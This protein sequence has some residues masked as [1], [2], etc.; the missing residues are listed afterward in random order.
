ML[1][2][3]AVKHSDRV[4]TE[5][6]NM[7]DQYEHESW[8]W[9]LPRNQRFSRNCEVPVVAD[10]LSMADRSLVA[11]DLILKCEFGL[12]IP[13]RIS[14]GNE[15]AQEFA[16]IV[17][18]EKSKA[19]MQQQLEVRKNTRNE[20]NLEEDSRRTC[21]LWE[22]IVKKREMQDKL[23]AAIHQL[24]L[25]WPAVVDVQNSM[26]TAEAAV[27]VARQKLV[28]GGLPAAKA[29]FIN[30]VIEDPCMNKTA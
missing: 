25:H 28:S 7:R 12:P 1:C 24:Q 13:R 2:A 9:M 4:K 6:K 10:S 8:S 3:S 26:A 27:E 22:E 18:K 30:G 15:A 21:A 11:V 20:V 5:R 14:S 17:E 16:R 29:T 23:D 19:E